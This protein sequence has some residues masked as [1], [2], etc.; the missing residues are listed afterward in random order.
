MEQ[1]RGIYAGRITNWSEV[2]GADLPIKAIS[3]ET[4]SGTY[5]V[6]RDLVMSGEP[7]VTSQPLQ[8]SSGDMVRTVAS[9]TGAIGYIGL[10]NLSASVKPLR[11][12]GVMGSIRTV[13]DGSYRINRPLF[14]F[15]RGWPAGLTLEFINYA[16]QELNVDFHLAVTTTLADGDMAGVYTACEDPRFLTRDTPNLR[17]KF[18]CNVRVSRRTRPGRDGSDSR[19][20]G[21]EAARIFL[22]RQR[23]M[24]GGHNEGFL[25]EQAKLYIIAVSDEEDQSRGPVGLY[26]DAFRQIKGVGNRDMISFSAITGQQNRQDCEAQR[27]SRYMELAANLNGVNQD[28]CA[29]NWRASMR[30]LGLDTFAYRT[31]FALTRRPRAESIEVRVNGQAVAQGQQGGQDG[32][33]YD[34]TNNSVIFNPNAVPVRGANIE[35]EYDTLCAQ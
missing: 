4:T 34:R 20:A 35:I 27:G 33:S 16:T 30:A 23:T 1:L 13:K 14:M 3:R 19:E 21:L 8:R 7:V 29:A 10:G 28:I 2:G 18:R 11:V 26:E 31:S 5:G 15:T 12:E 24:P 9:G 25:R 22:S 32:W 6:W 17:D